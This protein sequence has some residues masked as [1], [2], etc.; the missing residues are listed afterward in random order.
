M[1][2]YELTY[3]VSSQLGDEQTAG[4]IKEVADFVQSKN[5]IIVSSQKSQAQVLAYPVN[6]Q[7]SGYFITE[8]FQTNENDI[9]HLREMLNLRREVLRHLLLIKKA[10]KKMKERRTKKAA[11]VV[12]GFSANTTQKPAEQKEVSAVDLEKKLDEILS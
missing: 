6:K 9:Q 5:G 8:V 4:L 12:E 3:V 7:S 11:P 10:P 1:K 2:T